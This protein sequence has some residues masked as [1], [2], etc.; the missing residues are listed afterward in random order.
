MTLESKALLCAF[1]LL[2]GEAEDVTSRQARLGGTPSDL[3][4]YKTMSP[5]FR[6]ALVSQPSFRNAPNILCVPPEFAGSLPGFIIA[7][8]VS[9][10]NSYSRIQA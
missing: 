5:V 9:T 1:F 2:R 10:E 4:P 7:D 3:D 6:S 8:E